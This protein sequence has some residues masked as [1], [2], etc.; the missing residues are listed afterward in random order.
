MAVNPFSNHRLYGGG[1]SPGFAVH[2]F[3]FFLCEVHL[4]EVAETEKKKKNRR[5]TREMADNHQ[6]VCSAEAAAGPP[7]LLLCPMIKRRCKKA[8]LL[9]RKQTIK[10]NGFVLASLVLTGV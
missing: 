2:A 4:I 10:R 6:H 5:M 8:F 9:K 1:Y 7:A 3:L